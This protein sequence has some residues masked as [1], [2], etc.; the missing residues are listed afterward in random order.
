MKKGLVLAE[1]LLSIALL[2]IGTIV[3]A[4]TI[5]TAFSMTTFSKNMMIAQNLAT[6]GL[7][8]VKIIRNTNWILDPDDY[9]CWRRRIPSVS[10]DCA[11]TFDSDSDYVLEKPEDIWQLSVPSGLSL[12]LENGNENANNEYRLYLDNLS[13]EGS[14]YTY[15]NNSNGI[16]SPFYRQLKIDLADDDKATYTVTI[17]WKEGMKVRQIERTATIFNF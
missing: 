8:G 13:G 7:E 17:A 11:L 15:V 3:T 9:H 4:S 16:P 12:D 2:A 5:S 10:E 1:A 14:V 6:E